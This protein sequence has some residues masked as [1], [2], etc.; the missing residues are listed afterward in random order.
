ML[1]LSLSCA[2]LAFA[3]LAAA[4]DVARWSVGV[5]ASSK[6]Q[7]IAPFYKV[8][9]NDPGY[10]IHAGWQ[11]N[12]TWRIELAFQDFGDIQHDFCRQLPGVICGRVRD[13][14]SVKQRGVTAR[15]AYAW[16]LGAIQP[17]AAFGIGSISLD[18]RKS[19]GNRKTSNTDTGLIAEVG[20]EWK[21]DSRWSLR[22]GYE[23]V[24]AFSK[25][26]AAQLGILAH[27]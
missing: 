6:L 7:L 23:Y 27:F 10:K 18:T 26:G 8:L 16:T 9:S 20:L 1:K 17:F 25:D 3:N 5:A 4:Q 22:A 15:A 14:W 24:G 19:L 11:A 12:E 2:L 21:F 13:E